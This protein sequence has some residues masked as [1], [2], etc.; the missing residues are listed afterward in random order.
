MKSSVSKQLLHF[1]QWPHKVCKS[2]ANTLQ[3][4][5]QCQIYVNDSTVNFCK[6]INT[7]FCTYS[8]MM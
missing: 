4:C 8:I 1:V 3:V 5:L 7:L 2:H 6:Y